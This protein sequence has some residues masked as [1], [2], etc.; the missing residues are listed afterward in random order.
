M[1]VRDEEVRALIA[2]QAADWFVAHRDGSL[3]GNERQAFDEWLLA[4]PV[5]VEEYLGVALIA[6]ALPTAADDPESPL[7]AILERAGTRAGT[8]DEADVRLLRANISEP[9]AI[10]Q[11]PPV[12]N[13]W[14]FAVAALLAVVIG[15]FLW[16]NADHPAPQRY[17][18]G[19]GEQ[20]TWRLA[21]NSLLR[22]N[23]DTAV[24]VRYRPA[25]RLIEIDRGQ[26]FFGVA[27]EPTRRFRVVAG[28]TNIMAV[29]TQFDV[30][31]DRV[32]TVVTVVE[33]QVTVASDS[34]PRRELH[35]TAGGQ[36]RVMA[37]TLPDHA[38]RVDTQRSTAWLRRQIAFDQAPLAAVAAEFNRYGAVPI[39]IESPSLN[40]LAIS[41]VFVA[42]D[43]ETFLAFL[44]TLDDVTVE[45]T[46]TRIRVFRH[47]MAPG[48]RGETR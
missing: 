48:E 26:A 39:E 35:V 22:L 10:L 18:T 40:T 29:G 31:R 36:V 41:G 6:Q 33:G 37:G 7:D 16:W 12:R 19:H 32:S 8:V 45:T 5:H 42:D 23:T 46:S 17:A 20:K 28:T 47:S 30:Y 14:Q 44:R 13:R 11:G 24:T 25:E 9:P 43:T 4:S 34:T 21:D 38:S 2:R 27:H 1:T 3:G 15:G